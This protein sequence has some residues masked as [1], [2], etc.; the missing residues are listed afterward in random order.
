MEKSGVYKMFCG[1]CDGV[2]ISQTGRNFNIRKREH[3]NSYRLGKT[4]STFANHLLEAKHKPSTKFEVL[5]YAEK[6][7][8]LALLEAL[9][10]YKTKNGPENLL[11]DQTDLI[12]SSFFELVKNTNPI[13]PL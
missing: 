5:H 9:E 2:Y 10:I 7:S 13:N 1:E 11:N 12:F 4:D 3:L 8:K 6:E